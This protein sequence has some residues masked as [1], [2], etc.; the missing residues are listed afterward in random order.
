M[1]I[2]VTFQILQIFEE[3]VETTRSQSLG[4]LTL[5]HRIPPQDRQNTVLSVNQE[6]LLHSLNHWD[7][8]V[9]STYYNLLNFLFLLI[10]TI[11]YCPVPCFDLLEI[12]WFL[13]NTNL[14]FKSSLTHICCRTL[15]LFFIDWNARL[16]FIDWNARKCFHPFSRNSRYREQSWWAGWRDWKAATLRHLGCVFGLLNLLIYMILWLK[17]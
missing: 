1:S 10:Y 8:F 15:N 2:W 13:P 7:T 14:K 9:G 17:Q 6:G 16:F 5:W 12:N 3:D 4:H 11:V